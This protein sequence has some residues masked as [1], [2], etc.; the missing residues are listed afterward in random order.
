MKTL[1]LALGF[2]LSTVV[3][4]AEAATPRIQL[5]YKLNVENEPIFSVRG[6]NLLDSDVYRIRVTDN[7]MGETGWY[8]SKTG[9][10]EWD[11]NQNTGKFYIQLSDSLLQ[12]GYVFE[13]RTYRFSGAQYIETHRFRVGVPCDRNSFYDVFSDTIW[14]YESN[15]YSYR[16]CH[17]PI[18]EPTPVPLAPTQS[19]YV[20]AKANGDRSN[21]LV[22]C[23][24]ATGADVRVYQQS[25]GNLLCQENR[26]LTSSYT[27]ACAV[28]RSPYQR[29]D[30]LIEIRTANGELFSAKQTVVKDP[31][32]NHKPSGQYQQGLNIVPTKEE[33]WFGRGYYWQAS[34]SAVVTDDDVDSSEGRPHVKVELILLKDGAEKVIS[35]SHVNTGGTAQFALEHQYIK[36]KLFGKPRHTGNIDMGQNVLKIRIWDAYDGKNY[37]DLDE[38]TVDVHE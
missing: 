7:L 18:P 32:Y 12:Y 2:L 13:I 9:N 35:Y 37:V 19:C 8:K 28:T 16:N 3:S 20:D 33:K 21:I 14:V 6:E 34:I 10:I 22:K 38:V 36:P 31:T 23:N 17:D 4:S 15:Q 27:V 29:S 1:F 30:Y 25:T 5:N 26:Y 24:L 11:I